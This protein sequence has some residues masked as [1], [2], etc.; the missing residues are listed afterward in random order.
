MLDGKYHI[1]H[2]EDDESRFQSYCY[3]INGALGKRGI[4]HEIIWAGSIA[5]AYRCIMTRGDELDL[6]ILDISLDDK[7]G[8]TG[9]SIIR[10]V[11][12]TGRIIPMFVVSAN[13]ETYR[14]TLKEYK[15]KQLILGYSEPLNAAWPEQ[16]AE[17]LLGKDV[18]VLHLS[19]IHNGKF[20]A[21][22][23]LELSQNKTLDDLCN[24]LGHVD[25]VVVSGDISSTNDPRDYQEACVLLDNLRAKLSL[26][27]NSFVFVPGNH[28]RDLYR[29]DAHT[30]SNFLI[31]LKDFYRGHLQADSY[32]P[33]QELEDYDEGAQT[34]SELFSV[35]AYPQYRTIVVG[36]NSVN[37]LDVM[38]NRKK[39]CSV[40]TG[41]TLCGLTFGGS[42]SSEQLI[43]TRRQLEN[44]YIQHPEYKTFVKLATFHH[45]IFE[46]AHIERAE[47]RPT[48][49]NQGNVLDVLAEL[50]FL[51]VLHGHLH[52]SELHYYKAQSKPH[53]MNIISAGTFSGKERNMDPNFC[54]NKITYRVSQGGQ[55]LSCKVKRL[56]LPKDSIS[57]K[58]E[59]IILNDWQLNKQ[60]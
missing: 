55:V 36:L 30:F 33:S 21:L 40:H 20:F 47:W 37:P 60:I 5:D 9:L 10:A 25:F 48:I 3:M 13:V 23:N 17:I 59:E 14:E 6:I 52:Y 4:S 50:N 49:L 57:W 16:L 7:D 2:V 31:F 24:N 56:L 11:E 22:G 28:D 32:Y 35:V 1:L 46:A 12:K 51:F 27:P 58:S 39:D 26:E 54:A 8:E 38:D 42:I 43:N 29:N 19:D 44:L 15:T 18:N 41:G 45:N 34:F 53:G